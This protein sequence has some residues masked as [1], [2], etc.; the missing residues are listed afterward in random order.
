MKVLHI[1]PHLGGGVGKAHA[2]L[3]EAA[4]EAPGDRVAHSYALLEAPIDRS[5]FERIRAAGCAMTVAPGCDDLQALAAA[6]DIVQVEWWNHPR[7]YNLL[8]TDGLPAVRLVTWLHISGLASPLVPP[9][10]VELSD[11]TLFSS[12]CSFGAENLRGAILRRPDGFGLVPSGFGFGP[13][14]RPARR[15]GAPLRFGY[16]G[17]VDFG[18]MHPEF[19]DFIDAV[20]GDIRVDLWGA[21]APDGE[22]MRRAAAMRHPHRVAFRGYTD[23][24]ARVLSETDVFVYLLQPDHYGT[25]E[26]AL[27][28]AMSSGAVPLILANPAENAIVEHG[29]TG[30]IVRDKAEFAATV[31]GLLADPG[32]L[33]RLRAAA[34]ATAERHHSPAASLRMLHAAYDAALRWPKRQRDFAAALGLDAQSWFLSSLARGGDFAH[35]GERRFLSR[36]AAKGTLGHFLACIPNDR[37]LHEAFG[38]A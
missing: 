21:Y 38:W 3:M 23:D 22:A 26:N 10:L 32:R 4:R 7:L 2:A 16:L 36:V 25:G 37:S 18:K 29:R 9:R 17:T 8:A 11:Q 34:V 14:R 20:A 27:V 15:P 30:L 19:F 5:Y 12:S 24:P 31:D 35:P 33:R 28:E 1:T 13:V 6:A